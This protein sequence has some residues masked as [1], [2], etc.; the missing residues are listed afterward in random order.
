MGCTITFWIFWG[1]L[2]DILTGLSQ[3]KLRENH[4]DVQAAIPQEELHSFELLKEDGENKYTQTRL[5]GNNYLQAQWLMDYGPFS[6]TSG[7]PF[8]HRDLSG[9]DSTSTIEVGDN[10]LTQTQTINGAV[11]VKLVREFDG[12]KMTTTFSSPATDKTAVLK[13]ERN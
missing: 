4:K 11:E 9:S 8:T 13:F 12:D 6:F 2:Y 7:E 3:E 5:F 1:P 10:T